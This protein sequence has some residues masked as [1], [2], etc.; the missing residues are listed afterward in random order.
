MGNSRCLRVQMRK[1]LSF[2]SYTS[3]YV[4][5][6]EASARVALGTDSSA[7]ITSRSRL[8]AAPL[9]MCRLLQLVHD[10]PRPSS[11]HRRSAA[12]P[13][14]PPPSSPSYRPRPTTTSSSARETAD[15]AAPY[16]GTARRRRTSRRR[17]KG[18][19]TALSSLATAGDVR[20]ESKHVACCGT[21]RESG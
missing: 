17:S 3:T 6:P 20:G 19:C 2:A 12:P 1:A 16:C 21:S 13:N 18:R 15:S 8:R 5:Q 4:F 7:E 10:P 9:R 11:S 14:A